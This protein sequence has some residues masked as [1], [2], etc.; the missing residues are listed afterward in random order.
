MNSNNLLLHGLLLSL[1]FHHQYRY[2]I[3]KRLLVAKQKER[4]FE[5]RLSERL[6]TINPDV[7]VCTTANHVDI[8]VVV[9]LKGDIPLIVESHSIYR[10]TLGRKGFRNNL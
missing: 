9:K 8:N 6:H 2:G 7:I 10:M 5:R 4:Y 3:L 1:F